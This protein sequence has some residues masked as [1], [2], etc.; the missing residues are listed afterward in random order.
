MLQIIWKLI[1]KEFF[2][3]K[4]LY[5]VIFH[6]MFLCIIEDLSNFNSTYLHINLK[7]MIIQ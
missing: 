2:F 7:L 1:D 5:I 4:L 6:I 3:N